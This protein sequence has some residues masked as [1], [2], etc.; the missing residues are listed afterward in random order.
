MTREEG[1]KSSIEKWEE[2]IR[3]DLVGQRE[4]KYLDTYWRPCGYCAWITESRF[5]ICQDCPLNIDH[6]GMKICW[7]YYESDS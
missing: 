5:R 1:M 7:R 6:E 4:K 2:G 3:P